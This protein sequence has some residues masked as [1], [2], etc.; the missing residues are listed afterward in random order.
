MAKAKT[1]LILPV[2]LMDRVRAL[3]AIT[4]V[5]SQEFVRQ[6]LAAKLPGWEAAAEEGRP[7]D[8][9]QFDAPEFRRERHEK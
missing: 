9:Q 4:H 3:V 8:F 7:L 2:D 5:P 1:S 6:A